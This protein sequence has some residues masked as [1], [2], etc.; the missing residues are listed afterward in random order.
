MKKMKKIVVC[1]II[2]ISILLINESSYAMS[3]EDAGQALADFC[4][5]F[6]KHYGAKTMYSVAG[7]EVTYTGKTVDGYYKFDCVGWVDFAVHQCL[8]MG[9]P[10]M[11]YFAVPPGGGNTPYYREGFECIKGDYTNANNLLSRDE[12]E[13]TLQPG[14]ILF[15]GPEG[16]HVVIYVGD[17]NIIHCYSN[18]ECEDLY[19]NDMHYT[20]Y[21]AIGRITKS[22]A[23]GLNEDNIVTMFDG[24]GYDEK[25][26]DYK[27][28]TEG[29]YKGKKQSPSWLFENFVGFLDYLFGMFAYAIRAPFVGW[30]NIIENMV[31]DTIKDVSQ[32]NMV[33]TAPDDDSKKADGENTDNKKE[34]NEN[35]ENTNSSDG[36]EEKQ[37]L[38][39]YKPSANLKYGYEHRINIE[40]LIY[41]RIPLLDVD[42]FDVDLSENKSDAKVT[43]SDDSIIYKLREN[44]A[45]WYYTIRMVSIVSLLI[46]LI[47]LGIRL[48]ITT[49]AGEKAKYKSMLIA[50]LTSFIIVFTIHYFMIV[51]IKVNDYFVDVFKAT[52]VKYSGGVSMYD[53]I[54]TRAYSLKLSEGVPATVMY[55][56][57]IYY[58]LRFLF[59]YFKRYLTV[60]ILAL[61]GPIMAIK[62]AFDKINKG[63]SSS[64]VS[65]MKDF[66]LNVLLQSIHALL[67]TSLMII[68]YE[69]SMESIAGFIVAL[70]I[71]HFVFNA[72]E[73][74][75]K[76]FDFSSTS[77]DS[78]REDKNYFAEAF[79]ITTGLGYMTS[80]IVKFGFG[81]IKN[82]TK[83]VGNL[84]GLTGQ[85]AT[86]TVNRGIWAFRNRNTELR[87]LRNGGGV[88]YKPVDFVET[89]KK[90]SGKA[91]GNLA[92]LA[93]DKI[94]K[95]TGRR[96]LRLGLYKMKQRDPNLYKQ[97]KNMLK[98]NRKL[99]VQ[100][101][102]RS[103]S[104]SVKSI[105]TM[106]YLAAS[107]PMMVVEPKSGFTMFSTA[108]QDIKDT[109]VQ[110]TYYGHKSKKQI[111]GRR[112]RVAAV[113]LT[114]PVGYAVIKAMDTVNENI[115]DSK[116][117]M[118]TNLVLMDIQDAN[119]LTRDIEK[120]IEEINKDIEKQKKALA[121]DADKDKLEKEDRNA[122]KDAID[123][124]LDTILITTNLKRVVNNYMNKNNLERISESDVDGL[125][126]E[127]NIE[128]INSEIKHLANVK[129]TEINKL[130]N[131]A[132]KIKAKISN[133]ISETNTNI[134]LK[135]EMD[136]IQ[137][138]IANTE[139]AIQKEIMQ[140]QIIEKIGHQIVSYGDQNSGILKDAN[141]VAATIKEYMQNNN[142]GELQEIDIK[143]VAEY[144]AQKA[145]QGQFA[146]NQQSNSRG[147]SDSQRK[148]NITNIN[149]EIRNLSNARQKDINEL[150]KQVNKMRNKFSAT[151]DSSNLDSSIKKEFKE[152]QRELTKAEAAIQKE[153]NQQE[154]TQMIGTQIVG[155]GNLK[156][157][158]MN[159]K[160]K[161]NKI[162]Q[163]YK[164]NNGITELKEDD[165]KKVARYFNDQIRHDKFEKFMDKKELHKE[166][167]AENKK[168]EGIDKKATVNAMLDTNKKQK[169]KTDDFEEKYKEIAIKLRELAILNQKLINNHG[170]KN[171]IDIDKFIK[172]IKK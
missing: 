52:E 77:L 130:V 67:Y 165:V 30:A 150:K 114:G 146:V 134:S 101:F 8:K 64:I 5:N 65:W 80:G 9:G 18:L 89:V 118:K 16:P 73:I 15:C 27:G 132:E 162:I 138:D 28:T 123:K 109:A 135:D 66:A 139:L 32:V 60:N 50:W 88:Q 37:N 137:A 126:R 33:E 90:L 12:V 149:E 153:R 62:Y 116:K 40:D 115:K 72:E 71:L 69:M 169:I 91:G 106:T 70:I 1:I 110:S 158:Y 75:L 83:F 100:I 170:K 74:V 164:A 94:Y 133:A 127:L 151:V 41:N 22:A 2:F 34:E 157:S 125:L 95:I 113:V 124:M 68:A 136:K 97:T 6:Y 152:L 140:K 63:K 11:T 59:V 108:L 46:V 171:S 156:V 105:K 48:S 120:Q 23:A 10:S 53:T 102:K 92:T 86:S 142:I 159:D 154:I 17:H 54:R 163:E 78:V 99:N 119:S 21:C 112:G 166:I 25:G 131:K 44:V 19:D 84:A 128:D 104:G 38:G 103:I 122:R 98:A 145:K 82:T 14:D 155:F 13:D 143:K 3:Q 35:S 147:T 87:D 47:Y 79:A 51:V 81:G 55:M 144:F 58:L 43:I 167:K 129:Q 7:R 168:S 111:R 57:L 29:H 148:F 24:E 96:S 31:N 93:D 161:I 141:N 42:F 85:I 49:V 61:L 36:S 172:N 56:V 117:I 107:I 39:L 26:L 45:I 20:G 160:D 4:I 121:T 76:I